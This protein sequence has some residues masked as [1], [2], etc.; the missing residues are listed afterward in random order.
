MNVNSIVLNERIQTLKSLH[1]KSPLCKILEKAKQIY[2]EGRF[3]VAWTGG[4]WGLT[5]KGHVQIFAFNIGMYINYSR[6][7]MRQD[8]SLGPDLSELR[9]LV[10]T[11]F[12]Q[13][14]VLVVQYFE[15]EKF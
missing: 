7:Q 11:M 2:S 13:F 10:L 4:V 9:I 3:I 14:F 15:L 6:L 8:W 5:A 1:Y 12:Y